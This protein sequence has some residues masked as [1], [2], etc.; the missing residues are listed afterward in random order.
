M[1][2]RNTCLLIVLVCLQLLACDD[3][4]TLVSGNYTRG[5]LI[6][7]VEKG[8]L[9]KDE[10][11]DRVTELSASAFAQYGVSYEVIIPSLM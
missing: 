1:K 5:D 9:T 8:T 10:I 6:E 2:Y 11:V 7:T 4:D 3:D